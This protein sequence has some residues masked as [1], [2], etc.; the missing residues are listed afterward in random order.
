MRKPI[1]IDAYNL[2]KF[3]AKFFLLKNGMIIA[4]K[5]C[6]TKINFRWF[7][8]FTFTDLSNAMLSMPQPDMPGKMLP[9]VDSSG[10]KNQ[11]FARELSK[12]LEKAKPLE[13]KVLPEAIQKPDS[14][15]TGE[16]IEFLTQKLGDKKGAALLSELKKIFLM[17][18]KGDLKNVSIDKKG[19]EGLKQLLSKA[20]FNPEELD[21]LM[22]ELTQGLKEE[23]LTMDELFDQL[24]DLSIDDSADDDESDPDQCLEISALPVMES[25]FNVLNIPEEKIQDILLA[26]DKG[27]QGISLDVII[28]KLQQLQKKAFITHTR[29]EADGDNDQFTPLLKQLGLDVKDDV[30]NLKNTPLT[31]NELVAAFEKMR[32]QIKSHQA[33]DTINNT[34]NNTI[35]NTTGKVIGNT[36]SDITGPLEEIDTKTAVKDLFKGLGIEAIPEEKKIFEFSSDQVKDQ[37]KN[38]LLNPENQETDVKEGRA[39]GRNGKKTAKSRFIKDGL[40]KE[41]AAAPGEEAL[42]A[43]KEKT[44]ADKGI[45][46]HLKTQGSALTDQNQV[47]VSDAKVSENQS[48]HSLIKPKAGFRNLP[49]FVTQQVTR[50]IVRA[51]NQGENTLKIQLKPPELG[52]LMLTIDH[53]GGT[54]KVNIVTEHAAAKEI[55]ASNVNEVRSL[56]NNSGVTLERFDVD[57]DS[58]FRQSMADAKNQAGN[59]NKRRQNRTKQM[60]DPVM[61]TANNAISLLNAIEQGGSMHFVA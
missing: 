5:S 28:E 23:K 34:I 7:M 19:L 39:A 16:F 48:A 54:I 32:A 20:G 30:K 14:E 17:L 60:V 12:I 51:V 47:T 9:D 40:M 52:R 29:Y 22:D 61:D 42:N 33:V 35:D 44:Q 49:N 43:S 26:A 2:L 11:L 25:I 50:S 59:S 57:M 4:L 37:F 15:K 8:N 53:S 36:T 13:D 31:L 27:E 45:I 10:T 18:S 56:L 1:K 24:F 58:N 55:L 21:A 6:N 38:S 3:N 46:K 41:T